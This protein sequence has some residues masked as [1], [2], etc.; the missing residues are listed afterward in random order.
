MQY[1]FLFSAQYMYCNVL[2]KTFSNDGNL[3]WPSLLN[4]RAAE[5]WSLDLGRKDGK[6]DLE[7]GHWTVKFIFKEKV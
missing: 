3:Q 4:F 6:L 5:K 7:G 2:K 1:N